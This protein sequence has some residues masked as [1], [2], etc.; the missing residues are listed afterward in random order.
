MY[1]FELVTRTLDSSG[2]DCAIDAP[3]HSISE[4]SVP[5]RLHRDVSG[6]KEE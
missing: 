6:V 1:D 4:V 2:F 3:S 5:R